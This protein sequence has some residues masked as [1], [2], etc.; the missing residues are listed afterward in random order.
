M[1][2]S[3]IEAIRVPPRWIFVRV[4]TDDGLEG[5]GE[6]IVPKRANAALGAITDLADNIRGTDAGHIEDIWQR[7]HRDGFYRGGPVLGTAAAAIEIALWD[8]KGKRLGV[9]VH[10]LLGGPVRDRVRTYAWVGGDNPHDVVAH[11]KQRVEQ[12]FTAVKM[13]ATAA[14]DYLDRHSFVDDAIARVA[15]IREAFGPDL[16]IALDFH[17]RVH[18]AMARVLLKELEQFRLMWV[19]EAATP[20]AE[21]IYPTLRDAAG[22]TPLATGERLYSRWEFTRLLEMRAVDILQPDVSITGLY[23]LVKICHLAEPHDV[24]VAPHCPN[25]PLSLA[26]SLQAGYSCGNIVIQEQ[27]GGLHYHQ[28]FA[29][30]PSGELLDYV[31][32]P[33][34]LTQNNG[35]FERS[36]KPGLGLPLD[37]SAV[38]E[39]AQYWRYPDPGWRHEDGRTAEW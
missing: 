4:R 15:S 10:E 6:A 23:E 9:P 37:V 32:E 21:D 28:G 12:G 16:G 31:T 24:A 2:I 8:I 27:S 39:R 22:S 33:G 25:G 18:R 29:G 19:E 30:L 34:I 35:Y 5:W 36:D 20:E 38:V 1:R 26:A 7:M 17:G 13:N 14:L 11:V 3:E